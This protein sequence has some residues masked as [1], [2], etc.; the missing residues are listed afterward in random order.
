MTPRRIIAGDRAVWALA[1]ALGCAGGSAAA[2]GCRQGL[3]LGLDVSASVEPPEFRLA[4]DG[5]AAALETREV[6]A[7]FLAPGAPVALAIFEWSGAHTQE[8]VL[9]WTLVESADDLGRIAGVLRALPRPA[10]QGT[11]AIGAALTFAATLA[12]TAP[13]CGRVT[14]DFA[15]DGVN[16]DGLPPEVARGA[17]SLAGITVN[18]LAIGGEVPLGRLPDPLGV[19]TLERYFASHLIVGEGAFVETA[20]GF[21]DFEAAMVRKLLRELDTVVLGSA[22]VPTALVR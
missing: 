14:V 21:E 7:A 11:T 5:T 18:A 4:A 19:P 2:E 6:V 22:A 9:D 17:P 20:R 12:A 10:R 15:G 1:A 13:G 8:L 16:N 3:V